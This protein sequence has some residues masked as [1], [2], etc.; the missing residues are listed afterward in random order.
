MRQATFLSDC[1]MADTRVAYPEVPGCKERGGT[2][3]QAAV[4][5]QEQV[6]RL[7]AA[8]L[9]ALE[10]LKQAT[11]DEI[12]EHIGESPW[13]IRP[14]CSELVQKGLVRKTAERRRNRSGKSATVLELV[15]QQRGE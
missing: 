14:R 1:D 6:T 2:S 8:V 3:E 11:P 13:S 9:E 5:I 12:A 4:E 7:R 10:Q 15:F